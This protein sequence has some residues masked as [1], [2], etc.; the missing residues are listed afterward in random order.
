MA[1]H[2]PWRESETIPAY[3]ARSYFSHYVRL[4]ILAD[5]YKVSD[6]TGAQQTPD[7]SKAHQLGMGDNILTL[8]PP[9]PQAGRVARSAGWGRFT[10]LDGD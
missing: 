1:G 7:L 3:C 6:M 2:L 9:P 8:L 5:R 10:R 4:A